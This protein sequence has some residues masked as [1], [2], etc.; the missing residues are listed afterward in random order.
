MSLE[1]TN[2]PVAG[3]RPA[4][5]RL[6][7]WV[8]PAPEPIN[9]ALVKHAEQRAENVQNSSAGIE[10]PGFLEHL[11]L[12]KTA[13]TFANS[14]HHEQRRASDG[15]SFMSHPEE[16][17][18]L[19]YATGAADELMAAGL[20]H[21]AVELTPT[22]PAEIGD[23]FGPRVAELVGA[24][25]EDSTARS[26]RQRKAALR[27]QAVGAGEEAAA[28]FAADKL[29]KVR[30]YRVQLARADRGGRPPRQRQLNHYA[31]SLLDLERVIPRHPLV[32]ELRREL[33]PLTPLPTGTAAHA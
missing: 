28:L 23:R 18:A 19:L 15:A 30:E 26:Y 9:P 3:H 33:A 12:A 25:T 13:W 16:V 24:V 32:T 2:R 31:A 20:L 17:A 6:H 4:T 22:S 7:R 5:G 10:A 8:L 1:S 21:D 29:S 11:P 14:V 27:R